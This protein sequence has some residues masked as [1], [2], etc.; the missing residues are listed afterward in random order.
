MKLKRAELEYLN[1][2]HI[3]DPTAFMA[4]SHTREREIQELE[5]SRIK[6]LLPELKNTA[7][8][9]G[10]VIQGRIALKSRRSGYV[11]E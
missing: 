3:P 6:A 4:F 10:F 2:K 9:F 1:D 7:Y 11:Y 8:K 5:L